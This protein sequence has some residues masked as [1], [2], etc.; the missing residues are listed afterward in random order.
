[1]IIGDV[2]DKDGADD[3]VRTMLRLLRLVSFDRGWA[4]PAGPRGTRPPAAA[5]L[6][7]VRAAHRGAPPESTWGGFSKNFLCS[8]FCNMFQHFAIGSFFAGQNLANFRYSGLQQF[9]SNVF[10][11]KKDVFAHNW[12][13]HSPHSH[14]KRTQ[15]THTCSHLSGGTA[16]C[17]VFLSCG[18]IM[19]FYLRIV[20]SIHLYLEI[21]QHRSNWYT[22]MMMMMMLWWCWWFS[23]RLEKKPFGTTGSSEFTF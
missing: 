1:M 22:G 9:F 23:L 21:E 7:P 5:T 11:N 3:G 13:G 16:K 14:C 18:M 20:M 10:S 6:S 19:A 4:T 17:C 12:N 2:L 8:G 15:T